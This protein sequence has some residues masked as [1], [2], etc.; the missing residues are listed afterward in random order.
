MSEYVVD[1]SAAVDALAGKG[2]VGIA[3]RSKI[4]GATCHAPH[5]VDAEAGH[6]LRHIHRRGEINEEEALT[7]MRGLSSIIDHRYPHTGT[8]SNLAWELRDTVSFYDGLYVALAVMLDV[9][10][11]TS[12]AK[13]AKA[14]GLPCRCEVIA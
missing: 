3:L 1:A 10:L 13:L 7:A 12:D 6:V 14:P 9:P 2:S 11:L 4:T 8:M 5:L